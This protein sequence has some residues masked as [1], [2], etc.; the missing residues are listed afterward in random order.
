MKDRPA[1][2]VEARSFGIDICLNSRKA[3]HPDLCFTGSLGVS[4]LI[5]CKEYNQVHVAHVNG[6]SQLTGKSYV[7]GKSLLLWAPQKLI[8][9]PSRAA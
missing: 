6:P 2:R 5:W 4:I 3:H 8:Y 7:K 9:G 1:F